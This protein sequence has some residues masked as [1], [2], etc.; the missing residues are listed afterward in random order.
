M[1]LLFL[2]AW[3]LLSVTLLQIFT[4]ELTSR[5]NQ[6]KVVQMRHLNMKNKNK[7]T[8]WINF[9][10]P[11]LTLPIHKCLLKW[12]WHAIYNHEQGII[13]KS[14]KLSKIGVSLK[15][16]T[17]NFLAQLLKYA[18]WVAG[19]WLTII[20]KLFRYFLKIS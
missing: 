15:F 18:F 4:R 16:F 3:L 1:F 6:L 12:T 13:D 10:P 9:Y 7:G 2:F 14:T 8:Q 5:A 19:W 17:A 11:R 20:S